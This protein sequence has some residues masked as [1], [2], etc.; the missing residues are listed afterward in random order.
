MRIIAPMYS[1]DTFRKRWIHPHNK[2]G[3]NICAVSLK[4]YYINENES[5]VKLV[6]V[7]YL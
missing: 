2:N 6:W 4:Q 1:T 3:N 7:N 5:A